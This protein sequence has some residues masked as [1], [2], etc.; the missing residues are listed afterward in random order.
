MNSFRRIVF[1]VV[2]AS[3]FLVGCRSG[4][5]TTTTDEQPLAKVGEQALYPSD[6]L[7][8]GVGMAAQDS[9]YQLQVHIEQWVRDALMLQVAKRNITMTEQLK[10]KVQAYEA[11]L[12]MSQYEEA[13][14]NQRLDTEVTPQ[15]L[16]DYYSQNK[17]QYQAGISWVRCHFVKV[18]R[19]VEGIQDLKKWFK[20]ENGVDFERV[21]LFCAKNKT[22][23]ILNEDLWVE[24]DKLVEQLPPN[25]IKNRHRKGQSILDRST[26]SHQ[27]LLQIFEYRDKE[28]AAPL[29]QVQDEIR[30]II[31]HQRRNQILNDIR[32]EV[33]EQAKKEKGFEIY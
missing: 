21:K 8:I 18:R 25:A 13:L 5:T 10:R 9:L 3:I 12:L 24:Y 27:F 22:A 29:P 33:Y 4:E 2:I 19:G 32:R 28:D 14:I 30:R 6:V 15:Q 11:S 23:H 7:G 17:E 1:S 20:S 31:L 16:S 26:D